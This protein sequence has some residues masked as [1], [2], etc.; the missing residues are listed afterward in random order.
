[1]S[2]DKNTQD[3]S[4][5]FSK[6]APVFDQLYSE[7]MLSEYLRAIFRKEIRSHLSPG[8]SILEL[9]CGTG[10]DALYFA[11]LG[12]HLTAID[13]APGMIEQLNAKISKFHLE[14]KISTLLCSFH[15]ID[16]ITDQ[17]FDHIISNFGGLNCT[18][19]LK[20]VL[21]KLDPL[22]TPNGKVTLMI[23]P[24]ISPWELIMV[25]KGNFKTAFR[26]FKKGTPAQIEGHKF[27]CYYYNA[28]YVKRILKNNFN[29]LSLRGVSVFVP[30]EFYSNFVERYPR[31][32][33]VLKKVES[34][35][36]AYFPFNRCC[37]HYLIT[38]QKKSNSKII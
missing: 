12:H 18:N 26:R 11:E 9:N 25:F 8:S 15:A 35:V 29:V 22:L 32:F 1:M 23:M 36:G 21:T 3:V 28:G 2:L 34:V 38:L 20:D 14:E 33:S 7:N 19:N 5:A 10:M 17:K 4:A 24:K 6:Q 13:I 16:H 37:D 31:V 30:P 27:L